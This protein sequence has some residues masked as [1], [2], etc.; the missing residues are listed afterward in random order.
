MVD[1][2]SQHP[3]PLFNEVA[4]ADF[5][6]FQIAVLTATQM[7]YRNL[8]SARVLVPE[9][10]YQTQGWL[11]CDQQVI[12]HIDALKI[13]LVFSKNS[14]FRSIRRLAPS[15]PVFFEVM[16]SQ[17]LPTSIQSRSF[18]VCNLPSSDF[19]HHTVFRCISP[20]FVRIYPFSSSSS[21][22]EKVKCMLAERDSFIS[23]NYKRLK[24]VPFY[25]KN[26]GL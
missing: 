7:V 4:I 6:Q 12:A 16:S 17:P 13:G 26:F 21:L 11:I 20:R 24:Q 10:V 3:V 18:F 19:P 9:R 1:S 15:V 25:Q 23:Q 2:V 8:L 5:D 22:L 14:P